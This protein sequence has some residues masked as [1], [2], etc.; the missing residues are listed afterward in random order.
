MNIMKKF[1]LAVILLTGFCAWNEVNAQNMSHREKNKLMKQL[2]K[3][4]A[5]IDAKLKKM[6]QPSSASS[7]SSCQGSFQMF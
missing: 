4:E 5:R 7:S 1:M 6:E 2:Q 3:I